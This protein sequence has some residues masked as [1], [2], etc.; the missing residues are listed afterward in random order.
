MTKWLLILIMSLAITSPVLANEVNI[1]SLKAT[2]TELSLDDAARIKPLVALANFYI[3]IDP[4][5]TASYATQALAI[6]SI[7]DDHFNKAKLL[8]LL[9]Q[10]EMYQGLNQEAFTHLNQAINSSNNSRTFI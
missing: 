5:K 3:Y 9:G 6:S 2:L 7:D 8:R 1:D 4:V 10:A